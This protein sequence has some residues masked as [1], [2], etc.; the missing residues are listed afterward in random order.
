[1]LCRRGKPFF[2]SR[3]E[4]AFRE[5]MRGQSGTTLRMIGGAKSTKAPKF[6]GK[7]VFLK[8]FTFPPPLLPNTPE[9]SICI[10][11][12]ARDF[13]RNQA[14]DTKEPRLQVKR[15]HG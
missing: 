11:G 9:I 15:C 2:K 7:N 12:F 4:V 1:M 5:P 8:P 6:A 13:I 14:T 3:N 10:A